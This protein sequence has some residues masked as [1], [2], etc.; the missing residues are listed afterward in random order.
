MNVNS[1]YPMADPK[2]KGQDGLTLQRWEVILTLKILDTAVRAGGDAEWFWEAPADV[3]QRL[4]P[5]TPPRLEPLNAGR[6]WRRDFCDRLD[7]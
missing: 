6:P 7:R 5:K 2:N 1:F 3:D 4:K